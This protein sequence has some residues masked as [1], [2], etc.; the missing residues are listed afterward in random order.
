MSKVSFTNKTISV[1]NLTQEKVYANIVMNTQTIPSGSYLYLV[2]T[3]I[4]DSHSSYSSPSYTI[5]EDG[6]FSISFSFSLLS[7][8]GFNANNTAY[9]I[10]IELNGKTGF[11]SELYNLYTCGGTGGILG[12]AAYLNLVMTKTVSLSKDDVLKPFIYL[13]GTTTGYSIV[14]HN[15]ESIINIYKLSNYI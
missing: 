15:N 2:G 4:N 9:Q 14:N 12:S 5:P 1:K 6:L 10:G 13:A 8:T 3:A 7:S 11:L